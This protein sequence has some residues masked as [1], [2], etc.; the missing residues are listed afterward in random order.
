MVVDLDVK[1]PGIQFMVN[2]LISEY[3][4][5]VKAMVHTPMTLCSASLSLSGKG[6]ASRPGGFGN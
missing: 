2:F 1:L 3:L 5:Q 4:R 6:S